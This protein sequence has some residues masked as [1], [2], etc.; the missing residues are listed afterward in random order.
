MNRNDFAQQIKF[1]HPG[2]G[3]QVVGVPISPT[4][5]GNKVWFAVKQSKHKWGMTVYGDHY[6]PNLR[7]PDG[8]QWWGMHRHSTA[9]E[10]I[11]PLGPTTHKPSIWAAWEK[12]PGRWEV[13][14]FQFYSKDI[15]AIEF[16]LESIK[17]L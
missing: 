1:V 4:W 10:L 11:I 14:K 16:V 6:I 13:G 2:T 5:N 15:G 9:P 12:Y 8:L 7:F 3:N 17:R